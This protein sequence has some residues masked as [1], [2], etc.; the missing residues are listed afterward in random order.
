LSSLYLAET[1]LA[2]T[3]A[4]RRLLDGLSNRGCGLLAKEARDLAI[5]L[6]AASLNGREV[7]S[8]FRIS[9]TNDGLRLHGNLLV[10][11]SLAES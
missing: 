6:V 9:Q 4:W 8:A 11:S 5:R 7:V 3:G 10:P 1:A 2:A